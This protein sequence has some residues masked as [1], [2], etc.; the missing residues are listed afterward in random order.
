VSLCQTSHDAAAQQSTT[1]SQ[2]LP[3]S[4]QQP[5]SPLFDS[6]LAAASQTMGPLLLQMSP[7]AAT[8]LTTAQW[9][10]LFILHWRT[11]TPKY[12]YSPSSVGQGSTDV[13][14]Q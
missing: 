14:Q 11:A 9:F 3:Q 8:V 10:S 13:K 6:Y 4:A 5:D 12:A 1:L 7:L 2:T